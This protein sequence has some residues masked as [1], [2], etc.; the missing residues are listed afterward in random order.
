MV[1]GT[2][3]PLTQEQATAIEAFWAANPPL[4]PIQEQ[5]QLRAAV[6]AD[7]DAPTDRKSMLLRG[8]VLTILDELNGHAAKINAILTAIDSGSTLAQVRDNIAAIADYPARTAA[9]VRATLNGKVTAGDADI[10]GP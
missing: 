7:L 5:E 4:T 2:A 1:N 3:V 6:N 10:S 8:L 9:Q